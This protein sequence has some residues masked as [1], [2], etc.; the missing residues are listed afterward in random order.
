MTSTSTELARQRQPSMHTMEGYVV[1]VQSIW[2]ESAEVVPRLGKEMAGAILRYEVNIDGF[3]IGGIM[4]T[5][6]GKA[7][8]EVHDIATGERIISGDDITLPRTGLASFEHMPVATRSLVLFALRA[9]TWAKGV[10]MIGSTDPADLS[11]D[12][13]QSNLLILT[14]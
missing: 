10:D 3:T 7:D 8:L 11:E 9:A 14:R 6:T 1:E 2:G 5:L 13:E 12:A 4:N